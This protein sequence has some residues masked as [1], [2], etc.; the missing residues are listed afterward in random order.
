MQGSG[1]ETGGECKHQVGPSL[2]VL[3]GICVS[4]SRNISTENICGV[5]G[6]LERGKIFYSGNYLPSSDDWGLVFHL[7]LEEGCACSTFTPALSHTLE[8]IGWHASRCKHT[9]HL[10]LQARVLW[11]ATKHQVGWQSHVLQ[12]WHCLVVMCLSCFLHTHYRV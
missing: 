2:F 3:G 5:V 8:S 10:G 4:F 6:E 1:A 7:L 9:H 12:A 11:P